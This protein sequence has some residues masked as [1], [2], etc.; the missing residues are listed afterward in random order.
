LATYAMSLVD[1]P[2]EVYIWDGGLPQNP[3][4]PWNY[5]LTF[6]IGGL[7]N[8]YYGN[9]YFLR[10]GQITKVSCFDSFEERKFCILEKLLN[11]SQI[12]NFIQTPA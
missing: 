4:P 11:L 2:R 7:T 10:D 12:S 9:A 6:N 8:E 1:K 5:L 3:N